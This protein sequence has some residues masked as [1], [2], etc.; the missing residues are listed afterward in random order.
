MFYNGLQMGALPDFP[1]QKH[2]AAQRRRV[3]SRLLARLIW[4]PG[5]QQLCLQT[6]YGGQIAA[7]TYRGK[8][9][10]LP[11]THACTEEEQSH[12]KHKHYQDETDTPPPPTTE[13]LCGN[14]QSRVGAS[15][16]SL[17]GDQGTKEEVDCENGEW[18]NE[19]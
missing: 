12:T 2:W 1:F 17:M 4:L 14:C 13:E 5:S 10:R 6:Q 15:T 9:G 7:D 19:S 18:T 8:P 16:M 11:N 3:G